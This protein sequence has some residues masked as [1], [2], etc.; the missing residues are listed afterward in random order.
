MKMNKLYISAAAIFTI[1]TSCAKE[2]TQNYAETPESNIESGYLEFTTQTEFDDV[3]QSYIALEN[4][5][6]TETKS[7]SRKTAKN[8]TSIAE[9]QQSCLTKSGADSE[10]MTQDEFNI[11]QAKLLLPDP[12]LCHV[13][14]ATLRIAVENDFYKITPY[15]TFV[16]R[17]GNEDELYAAIANFEQTKLDLNI[18]ENDSVVDITPSVKFINTFRNNPIRSNI[19]N[20]IEEEYGDN[21]VA[22]ADEDVVT[23]AA[24]ATKYYSAYSNV[25]SYRWSSKTIVGK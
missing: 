11:M 3:I 19:V 21:L 12:V 17:K 23:K 24:G 18:A 8:F 20:D 14:D 13:L 22:V 10:E 6:F 15:G 4:N 7:I 25:D 9:L 2:G 16:T 5:S 1:A